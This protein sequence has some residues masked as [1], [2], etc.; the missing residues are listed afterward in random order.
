MTPL[1]SRRT[2]DHRIREMICETGDPGLFPELKIR[3][4]TIRSWLRRGVSDVS[5]DGI[6]FCLFARGVPEFPLLGPEAAERLGLR[7]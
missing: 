4:S 2:Y 5:G 7:G 1:R 3:R 6:A